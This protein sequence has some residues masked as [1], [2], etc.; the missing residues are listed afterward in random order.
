MAIFFTLKERFNKLIRVNNYIKLLYFGGIMLYS[1]IVFF[2]VIL[3]FCSIKIVK[4]SCLETFNKVL[5]I[6]FI[7]QDLNHK[8]D[9]IYNSRLLKNIFTKDLLKLE[10]KYTSGGES[11]MDMF[12]SINCSK[13]DDIMNSSVIYNALKFMSPLGADVKALLNYIE[14]IL[15][16]QSDDGA[17]ADYITAKNYIFSGDPISS[18]ALVYLVTT[19][20]NYTGNTEFLQKKY[21]Y[22]ANAKNTAINKIESNEIKET[23]YNHC[24]QA[25]NYCKD[26]LNQDNLLSVYNKK[27]FL[28]FGFDNDL[29]A[30]YSYFF[31]MACEKFV[32]FIASS[33]ER[34]ILLMYIS[35]TKSAII[36]KYKTSVFG[37]KKYVGMALKLACNYS[38]AKDDFLEELYLLTRA[39]IEKNGLDFTH[40]FV[41]QVFYNK[42]NFLFAD[43]LTVL[44][45][46]NYIK[47]QAQNNIYR[48]PLQIILKNIIISGYYGIRF[49]CG[50]LTFKQRKSDFRIS[51]KH[52]EKQ[53]I[54]EFG[55]I[56]AGIRVNGL[57]LNSLDYIN[58]KGY[59]KDIHIQIASG[60]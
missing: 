47:T 8:C 36:S 45:V 57:S 29:P 28:D 26:N 13:T 19:Y 4:L 21:G 12:Y 31:C 56:N 40:L 18:A 30:V 60:E 5:T 10:K 24:V 20:I 3:V 2:V 27:F 23:V 49:S 32:P 16:T 46:E 34:K 11:I 55:G 35:E 43:K 6:N 37:L 7:E 51:F 39:S 41:A 44:L 14:K 9:S 52:L 58:L 25:L 1:S 38:E 22:R 33:D 54:S 17:C 15:Q 53:I 48:E 50:H 42:S 59:N